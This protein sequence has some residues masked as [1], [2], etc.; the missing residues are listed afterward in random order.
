MDQAPPVSQFQTPDVN[1]VKPP[2]EFDQPASIIANSKYDTYEVHL[3]R[4]QSTYS[5]GKYTVSS[6]QILMEETTNIRRNWIKEDKPPVVDTIQ[7]FPYL[8][9]LKFVSHL[10]YF[11][12]ARDA[13]TIAS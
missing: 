2:E 6:I 5:S 4:L 13:K 12:I 1:D 3:A 10:N 11:K 9:D 7:K 8:K